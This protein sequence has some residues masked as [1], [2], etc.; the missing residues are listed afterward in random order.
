MLKL[1]GAPESVLSRCTHAVANTGGAPFPLTDAG[2]SDI[3]R[4]V[5]KSFGKSVL[6]PQLRYLFMLSA[7]MTRTI[8][9]VNLKTCMLCTGCFVFAAILRICVRQVEE[10]GGAQALRCLALA[11]RSIP[12]QRRQV[13][14]HS[15]ET[16]G[17]SCAAR[18]ASKRMS[19][20]AQ[21]SQQV[22]DVSLEMWRG[23]AGSSAG[24]CVGNAPEQLHQR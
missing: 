14:S 7:I 2:R 23:S 6:H 5:A 24:R 21:C 9:H 16:R 10:L 11:S 8:V 13:G 17:S 18:S 15:D 19:R 1:Q 4:Q 12:A 3:L 20:A 22:R